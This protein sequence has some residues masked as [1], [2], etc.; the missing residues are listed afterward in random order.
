MAV[1]D[2]TRV[3][4]FI[5]ESTQLY[6]RRRGGGRS[7]VSS[8]DCDHDDSD[9]DSVISLD[10]LLGDHLFL[11]SSTFDMCMEEVDDEIHSYTIMKQPC[12][13]DE[14]NGSS[15]LYCSASNA[16]GR[17]SVGFNLKRSRDAFLLESRGLPK[18]DAGTL[19]VSRFDNDP[20]HE[21]KGESSSSR[22]PRRSAASASAMAPPRTPPRS[23]S[24]PHSKPKKRKEQSQSPTRMEPSSP[25]ERKS[26]IHHHQ[27]KKR[28]EPQSPSNKERSPSHIRAL[29]RINTSSWDLPKI[30]ADPRLHR[31]GGYFV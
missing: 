30:P 17:L 2:I 31:R 25:K 14:A 8:S 22:P 21:G 16:G 1:P 10:S 24:S 7:V 19:D 3:H 4:T 12:A 28:K 26:P 5:A 9:C 6:D 11:S 20:W 27:Q 29:S 15:V 18:L 13:T 23:P